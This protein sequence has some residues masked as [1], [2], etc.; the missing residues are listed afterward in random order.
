M[1]QIVAGA[2]RTWM[3]ADRGERLIRGEVSPIVWFGEEDSN[4]Q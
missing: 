1:V 4:P 3:F 2:P